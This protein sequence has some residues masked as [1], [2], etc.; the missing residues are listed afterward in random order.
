MRDKLGI[1]LVVTGDNVIVIFV[2]VMG[3]DLIVMAVVVMCVC[4][5]GGVI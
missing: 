4:V 5:W 3:N 2:I 1:V